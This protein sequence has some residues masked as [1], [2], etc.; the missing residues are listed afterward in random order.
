MTSEERAWMAGLF[1]GEGCFTMRRNHTLRME[2]AMTD[3]DVVERFAKLAG[4]GN[5]NSLDKR[6]HQR[7]E[8]WRW[9]ISGEK[10]IALALELRPWLGTRRGARVDEILA[11]REA[12]VLEAT[13]LRVCP[14][15]GKEF[16]PTWNKVSLRKVFCSKACAWPQEKHTAYKREWREG[17][18]KQ[19][20]T[21]T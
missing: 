16:R 9:S 6:V 15:C 7:K 14:T 18:R 21:V 10:A 17:R 20:L 8:Q 13:R 19:G 4:V 5:V 12:H 2:I 1:E 11:A 3:R